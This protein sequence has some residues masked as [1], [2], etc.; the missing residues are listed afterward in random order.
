M[1]PLLYACNWKMY[2]SV[3]EEIMLFEQHKEEYAELTTQ[4]TIALFPS[5]LA[6]PTIAASHSLIKLGAQDCSDAPQGAYTG[7][8]SAKSLAQLGCTYCIIGH[9]ERRKL[10]ETSEL[11]AQKMLRLYENNIIPIVC[12]GENHDQYDAGQADKVI[13]DQLSPLLDVLKDTHNKSLIIAYEPV[14]AIGT[15]VTPTAQEIQTAFSTIETV[16]KERASNLSLILLY[17]GSVKSTN[18]QEFKKIPHIGGFLI[19]HAS[20]DFQEFKKTVLS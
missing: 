9:S 17:G 11:I 3:Q 7:Q 5:Y 10:G 16:V 4:A 8:I 12:I 20:I 13:K 18:V 14:W 2:M 6:L 19:G 1:T 15:N